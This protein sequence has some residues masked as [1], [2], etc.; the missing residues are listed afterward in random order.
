MLEKE[1]FHGPNNKNKDKTV[2]GLIEL[3]YRLMISLVFLNPY[4]LDTHYQNFHIRIPYVLVCTGP[5]I[6]LLQQTGN[7]KTRIWAIIISQY[8]PE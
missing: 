8:N 1:T 5:N 3:G 4:D 7:I 6:S 2:L